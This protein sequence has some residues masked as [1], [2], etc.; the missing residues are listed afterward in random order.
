[1]DER[2]L[3]VLDLDETLV[4][5]SETPLPIAAEHEVGRYLLYLGPGL[6]SFLECVAPAYRLAVWTSSS[7]SYAHAVCPLVFTRSERLEFIWASDRCTP[8]RHIETD[9]WCNAKPLNKLKRLGYDLGRVLVVDDSPEKHTRNY[10]NLVQIAPFTGDPDDKELLHLAEYLSRLAVESDF[11]R[12]EK[13]AWRR[14]IA[15]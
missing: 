5:A 7:P 15:R 4:H 13:R 6:R 9:S 12:V 11:R 3:L 14:N 2:P 10:G 1:M 8:T